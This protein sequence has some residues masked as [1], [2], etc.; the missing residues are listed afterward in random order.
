MKL[1]TILL[2]L[3]LLSFLSFQACMQAASDR[4]INVDELSQNSQTTYKVEVGK[5]I[6][7]KT[8]V[9][10]SVGM[11]ADYEILD[12]KILHLEDNKVILDNP[13]FEGVGGDSGM[14]KFT[15]KALS[16]GKTKVT[17]KKVFRGNLE[18]E[19]ILEVEGI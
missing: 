2:L 5:T 8:K 17:I 16:K 14:A 10:G 12:E 7:F 19:I 15:F 1:K 18:K 13:D 6:S 4:S 9:H 3:F 11:G